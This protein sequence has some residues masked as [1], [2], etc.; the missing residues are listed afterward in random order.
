MTPKFLP[1]SDSFISRVVSGLTLT[2]L[3]VGCSPKS[4]DASKSSSS[5]DS[6]AATAAPAT[7]D[8]DHQQCFACEGKGTGACKAG[9]ASGQVECPGPCLKLT[10]GK[11]EHMNV[12]GHS[13]TELWQKFPN[14]PGQWTAWTQ[15]HVGE[16]IV[17]K[18][19]KAENIG[20]CKQCGGST[21]IQCT[22]CGGKGQ[23]VCEYC[24]GTKLVPVD[25]KPDD[26][27]VLNR[28]PDLIRLKDGRA[29]LGRV[30]MRSGTKYTIKTRDGKMVSI[31]ASEIVPK[32][33]TKT[34]APAL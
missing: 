12:A 16:V 7:P 33:V 27:P 22:V 28:Q 14:G 5:A 20:K 6:A 15:G 32:A 2:L 26:N 31:D 25:W 13:P 24:E 17:V 21:K 3:M 9:C 23:Q 1:F 19:G 11:W 34:N 18:N 29:L 8:K 10:R 30:A 4:S